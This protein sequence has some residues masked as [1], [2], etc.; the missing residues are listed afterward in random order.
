METLLGGGEPPN[1]KEAWIRLKGW[2]VA[3]EVN[4]LRRDP[5]ERSSSERRCPVDRSLI[6]SL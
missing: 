1:S 5:L 3:V 4:P 6:P 2:Y